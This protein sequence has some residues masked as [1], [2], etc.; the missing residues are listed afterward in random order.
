MYEQLQQLYEKHKDEGFEVLAFPCNQFGKQEPGSNKDIKEFVASKGAK[1]TVFD[2]IEVNGKNAH[3]LFLYLRKELKGT[4]GSSVKWNFTKFLCDRQGKPQ[5][6]Y[7]PPS[8]PL[9]FEDDVVT[10]LKEEAK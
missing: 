1:F 9:N 10:Y 6:R 7:A 5:K 3:P 4:L 8:K 2:K